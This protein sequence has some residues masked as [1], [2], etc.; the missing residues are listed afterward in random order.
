[1]SQS[2]R[3]VSGGMPK[4]QDSLLQLREKAKLES[5][6]ITADQIAKAYECHDQSPRRDRFLSENRKTVK[7][8]ADSTRHEERLAK[9]LYL[10]GELTLQ[11]GTKLRLLDYQFPLKQKQNDKGVGKIDLVGIIKKQLALV[12]LKTK[13]NTE[14]PRRALLEILFYGAIV[15]ENFAKI[16]NE[17]D[18]KIREEFEKT[19]QVELSGGVQYIVLAPP[20]YWDR[21]REKGR[22]DKWKAFCALCSELQKRPHAIDVQCLAFEVK[23]KGITLEDRP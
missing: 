4:K 19:E 11:N 14:N 15:K 7:V 6:E 16:K 20:E 13:D 18:A 21:W 22:I 1:M 9:A 5:N 2:T 10:L 3:T 8:S 12:E 23:T 17:I